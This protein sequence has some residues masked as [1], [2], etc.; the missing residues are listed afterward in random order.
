MSKILI[1]TDTV[2]GITRIV[3]PSEAFDKNNDKEKHKELIYDINRPTYGSSRFK[4]K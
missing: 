4:R 2:H 1:I 3:Q